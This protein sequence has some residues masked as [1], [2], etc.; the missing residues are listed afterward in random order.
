MSSPRNDRLLDV[1]T[2]TRDEDSFPQAVEE[3][4]GNEPADTRPDDAAMPAFAP[5]TVAGD[6]GRL[7][8]YRIQKELGRGGMGAV[9][10]A[11]DERLQRK[12]AL[13]IMLPRAAANGSAKERFLREAR[14]A[15]QI[16]SDHVVNIFEADEIAGVPYIA[17]Q[18]LQG[19]PLD[20]YLKKNGLPTIP[21]VIRIGRET[22]LGLAAAH[23]LGLVHRD[24]KPANLWLEAPTGRVKVLDFGLAKPVVGADTAEL[25]GSGAVVGT[26]SYMAP[27]QGMGKPVDGRADL[28]SLGCVLY[29]LCT[30][31]LPFEGPTVMAILCALATEEPTPVEDLNPAVPAPL[32]D[33]IRR[34]LAKKPA[35]RPQSAAAVAEELA[36][37]TDGTAKVLPKAVYVPMPLTG[38]SADA[39]PNAF[40]DLTD[41]DSDDDDSDDIPPPEATRAKPRGSR[42]WLIGGIVAAVL[43]VVAAGVIIIKITNKDGSTTEIKVPD[44]AKIEVDGKPVVTVGPDDKATQLKGVGDALR[45]LGGRGGLEFN[46]A[47]SRVEIPTL[48]LTATD[49]TTVE[50]WASPGP[51]R[52]NGTLFE[53]A[54]DGRMLKLHHVDRFWMG[55]AWN[56]EKTCLEFHESPAPPLPQ[57]VHVALCW[58]GKSQALFVNGVKVASES[59]LYPCP[60]PQSRPALIGCM[61]LGVGKY[62]ECFGGVIAEVRVSKSIRYTDKFTPQARFEKDADALALYHCDAGTG[63]VLKDSSGNNHDGK[64]VGAKWVAADPDRAA[65]EWLLARSAT[66]GYSDAAGYHHVPPGKKVA[67]SAGQIAVNNFKLTKKELTADADLEPFRG[68]QQLDTVVLNETAISDASCELLATLPGLRKL[69]LNDAAIT[70]PRLKLLAKASQ[71]VVL[72]LGGTNVTDAGL[73]HLAGLGALRHLLLYKTDVTDAGVK[74]LAAK[75]PNCKVEWNGG[76]IAPIAADPDRAAAVYVLSIGGAVRIDDDERYIK[77]VADLPLQAFRLGWV[78]LQDNKAVTDEGLASFKGCKNLI[79]LDLARTNVTDAGLAHFK[80]CTTLA[81][82]YLTATDVTDA[83]LAHLKDCKKLTVFALNGTRVTD[84][85]LAH[86]KDC[87]NLRNL[88]LY[89][90]T[91]VTNAGLALFQNFDGLEYLDLGATSVTDAGLAR[92]KDCKTLIG[93]WLNQTRVTDAGLAHFKDCTNLTALDLGH[94]GVTDAG[95]AHFKDWKTLTSLRLWGVAGV[96]DIGVAHFKSCK[97]L[98][99]LDVRKTKVTAAKYEE[100]K[101]AFPKCKIESDHGTHEPK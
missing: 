97:G 44:G 38:G 64:I 83:G 42:G 7:G 77:A 39:D 84:A 87:K 85:G 79:L 28:F 52:G 1:P 94:T 91:K 51:M 41:P 80:D 72:Q 21:Q 5:P 8:K 74:K 63:D 86:I 22:A 98:T 56:A 75:L 18:Y 99:A 60:R 62:S 73:E 67:L 46:G 89:G 6:L 9:Y 45:D 92:F 36:A 23:Q 20:E 11:F 65:A 96:S 90:A 47:D 3:T 70:D 55:D 25:T 59:K 49:P 16:G 19:Y 81:E 66:F 76:V 48:Q 12:V 61:T 88:H 69:Y 100:L 54:G 57:W 33:L 78:N 31:R 13:K 50:V 2:V 17:L 30:F 35:D 93:L 15:A 40:A 24:I 10:L 34:L 68:L 4:D 58:D 37:M 27:E 53:V 14:A 71:L 43:T 101:K 95:L 82:L 29:R 26:P 32:A